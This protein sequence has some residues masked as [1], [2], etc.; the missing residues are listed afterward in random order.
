MRALVL[1]PFY[2]LRE[3]CDRKAGDVIDVSAERY[4]EILSRGAYVKRTQTRK[5]AEKAAEEG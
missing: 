5:R 4:E 2:D 1:V 3:R